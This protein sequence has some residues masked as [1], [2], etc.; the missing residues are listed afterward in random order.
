M[1]TQLEQD[2]EQ[3]VIAYLQIEVIEHND[4]PWEYVHKGIRHQ[5]VVGESLEW[6]LGNMCDG[7]GWVEVPKYLIT[8]EE[9]IACS[10]L[11]GNSGFIFTDSTRENCLKLALEIMPKYMRDNLMLALTLYKL[12]K[13]DG[14]GYEFSGFIDNSVYQE[15]DIAHY[16]Y[17]DLKGFQDLLGSCVTDDESVDEIIRLTFPGIPLAECLSIVEEEEDYEQDEMTDED[18]KA[19]F[20]KMFFECMVF[21]RFVPAS[22]KEQGHSYLKIWEYLRNNQEK[23]FTANQLAE[24]FECTPQWIRDAI[25]TMRK[26][27]IDIFGH[28]RKGYI[29]RTSVVDQLFADS[30]NKGN[31]NE[32]H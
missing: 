32:K 3:A 26:Q 23:W 8:E 7:E 6:V 2:L 16:L 9:F 18:Q 10:A 29:L 20:K 15:F 4:Q 28:T 25:G 13:C 14:E 24:Q 11:L 27:G 31:T 17:Y 22:I 12:S 30:K 5:C 21:E 1:T 19:Q